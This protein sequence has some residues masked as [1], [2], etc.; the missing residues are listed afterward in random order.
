VKIDKP[1]LEAVQRLHWPAQALLAG[2]IAAPDL[3]HL[4]PQIVDDFHKSGSFPQVKNSCGYANGKFMVYKPSLWDYQNKNQVPLK[5]FACQAVGRLTQQGAGE[6]CLA[7]VDEDGSGL[8]I[9]I[10]TGHGYRI[11]PSPKNPSVN[12]SLQK[13]WTKHPALNFAIEANSLLIISQGRTVEVYANGTAICSPLVL[14]QPF[15][16]PTIKIGANALAAPAEFHEFRLWPQL[17]DLPSLEKRGA[18]VSQ[19]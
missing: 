3:S 17:S 5:D 10:G 18:L 9:A 1:V 7:L 8:L 15:K 13:P 12:Q 2:Q 6:W 14:D 4:Q 19:R 16:N 11:A